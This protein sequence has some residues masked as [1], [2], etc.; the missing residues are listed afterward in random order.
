MDF[1]KNIKGMLSA[2]DSK[3]LSSKRTIT[4]LAFILVSIAFFGDLFF[5]FNID[6]NI[7]DGVLQLVYVGVGAVLGEHLLKKKNTNIEPP[8]QLKDEVNK[9]STNSKIGEEVLG[10]N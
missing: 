3:N 4:F 5:N 8:T 9:E 6:Q 10:D 2:D 1:L 7:F